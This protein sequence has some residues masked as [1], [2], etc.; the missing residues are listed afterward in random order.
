MRFG[1]IALSM[2]FVIVV[3]AG[4]AANNSANPVSATVTPTLTQQPPTATPTATLVPTATPTPAPTNH[5]GWMPEG[6]IAR[7]GMGRYNAMAVSPD[8]SIVAVAGT[9]GV[10][11]IDPLT[12]AT[13]DFLET[14]TDAEDVA[15]SPDGKQMYVGLGLQGVSIWG[16]D[17]TNSWEEQEIFPYPSAY[18]VAIS[19]SNEIL[20]TKGSNTTNSKFIAWDLA[21]KTQ[22]YQNNYA[23]A[24]TSFAMAFSPVDSD[25]MAIAA[26]SIVTVMNVKGAKTI[27]TFVEPN[28]NQVLDLDFSPDGSK[29]AITS[30]ST[31]VI[32]LNAETAEETG[33]IKHTSEI[34]QFFFV[35]NETVVAFSKDTVIVENLK[36]K[37]IKKLNYSL[38]K[39]ATPVYA[40]VPNR[41]IIVM[42]DGESVKSISLD[43]YET[44]GKI[45][46]FNFSPP[47]YID[48]AGTSAL[49][50]GDG[51]AFWGGDRIIYPD[52]IKKYQLI[53]IN[54]ACGSEVSV[55]RKFADNDGK[56]LLLPCESGKLIVVET[57]TMKI[58]STYDDAKFLAGRADRTGDFTSN[59]FVNEHPWPDKQELLV[60]IYENSNEFKKIEIW[61]PITNTKISTID[62]VVPIKTVF[63][64]I[65]PN[66]KYI[67]VTALDGK[68][69]QAYDIATGALVQDI[70]LSTPAQAD[71]SLISGVFLDG[72]DLFFMRHDTYVEAYSIESGVMLRKFNFK[73]PKSNTC[74][75]D[76]NNFAYFSKTKTFTTYN[77]AGTRKNP[78]V[79]FTSYDIE[80]GEKVST[81][82]V[83]IPEGMYATYIYMPPEKNGDVAVVMAYGEG[84]YFKNEAIDI[85][86][87]IV[88]IPTNTIL[89]SYTGLRTRPSWESFVAFKDF[90][91]YH[92]NTFDDV[93]FL[94]DISTP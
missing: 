5:P 42:G 54:K 3:L 47:R 72:D 80:S 57:E 29:L 74:R 8:N 31:E 14:G 82:S 37:A 52:S 75:G 76:C 40:Y 24:K 36:A 15:F 25:L 68:S 67:V 17:E 71:S 88:D 65:S 10:H 85:A 32:L 30:G 12:G 81:I 28:K 22:R 18:R 89:K 78:M 70:E 9:G 94:Y 79:D 50:S 92:P 66:S 62:T 2:L 6:V 49:I 87:Y 58:V 34:L 21:T 48:F 1:K 33:R 77:S 64:R 91:L 7:F 55:F 45:E 61:N 16:L 13:I 86:L 19:P 11:F 69:I 44:L 27:G 35:D 93:Y 38:Y 46:E 23:Q 84:D 83:Q 20:F 39:S 73:L 26:N 51:K 53:D 90:L 56:Y 63:T 41:H 60:L 43:T 59:T 4:C